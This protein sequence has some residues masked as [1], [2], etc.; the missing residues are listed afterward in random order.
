M[1]IDIRKPLKKMLPY[2]LQAQ[3]DSL[4]EADTVLL[5]IR[6]FEGVLGWD[7]IGELSREAHLKNKF[8]D[9]VLKLDGVTKL[10]VE[11]KAAGEK[12]R[13]RHV[14]QAELYASENNFHWV[15]LTNGV[16]WNLYHLTFDDGIDYEKA[17]SIDLSDAS[18]DANA[19]RLALLHKQAIKK[20]EQEAFW[21][22]TAALNPESVGRFLFDEQVLSLMRR[23]IHNSEGVLLDVE[24]IAGAIHDLFSDDAREKIGPPKLRHHQHKPKRPGDA[25]AGKAVVEIADSNRTPTTEQSPS[26]HLE[27]EKPQKSQ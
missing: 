5:L 4:N 7:A 24:D 19:E 22:R 11:A 12:L 8:V 2:L 18:F 9:I 26:A 20:G 6:I 23:K 14:E 21:E 25:A 16:V 15:V 27:G 10:L 13:D 3:K 1:P 17:F